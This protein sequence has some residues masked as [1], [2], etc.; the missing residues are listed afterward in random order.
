MTNIRALFCGDR[1]WGNRF[2][3][4]AALKNLPPDSVIITGGARGADTLAYQ[5]ALLLGFKGYHNLVFKPE[6]DEHDRSAGPIRNRR[7]LKEALPTIIYAFHT[8]IKD[9]RG[10]KN[11]IEQAEAAGLPVILIEE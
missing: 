9:S 3:I 8:N 1:D 6:W 2:P 7:M 11:M 10:T 5:E 4:K